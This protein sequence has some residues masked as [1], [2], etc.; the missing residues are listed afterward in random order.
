M[1]PAAAFD[2]VKDDRL[3]SRRRIQNEDIV[4]IIKNYDV[5]LSRL[6]QIKE[7][8]KSPVGLIVEAVVRPRTAG[9]SGFYGNQIIGQSHS[10]ID[11]GVGPN[12]NNVESRLIKN[13][14]PLNENPS[15]GN[16]ARLLMGD[17]IGVRTR[18]PGSRCVRETVSPP[19][20]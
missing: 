14:S 12:A 18:S 1:P 4:V 3:G 16:F 6:V 20:C 10:E 13:V 8:A 11:A 2:L 19:T 17:G 15:S 7:V 9:L 5:V